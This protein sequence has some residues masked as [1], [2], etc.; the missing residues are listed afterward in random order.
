MEEKV[1][2]EVEEEA[3]E[4]EE[5]EGEVEIDLG[6]VEGIAMEVEAVDLEI[7]QEIV[8][9]Q[10]VDLAAVEEAMVVME[11]MVVEGMEMGEMGF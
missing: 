5:G 10:A 1:E 8:R 2:E 11:D 6:A 3:E 4:V 9:D 7:D